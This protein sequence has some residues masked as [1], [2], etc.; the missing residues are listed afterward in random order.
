[1]G[2]SIMKSKYPFHTAEVLKNFSP[3]PD[4][5]PPSSLILHKNKI[6]FIAQTNGKFVLWKSDG[7]TETTVSIWNFHGPV[8]HLTSSGEFIYFFDNDG[9]HGNELWRSDG[10][11]EGTAMVRDIV[12]GSTGLP[13]TLNPIVNVNGILYFVTDD[14]EHGYELWKSDGTES[15]TIMVRDIAQGSTSSDPKELSALNGQLYF[16]ADDRIYGRELWKTDGTTEG[17]QMLNDLNQGAYS[18]SPTTF[19][20]HKNVLYFTAYNNIVRTL[21]KTNGNACGTIM[22]TSNN[23]VSLED[24]MEI[25][26]NKI[27]V[28]GWRA[29]TGM[30]L[31]LHNIDNDIPISEECK[32]VQEII[33][34]Q[35]DSKT[36]GQLFQLKASS[37][38]DMPIEFTTT[39]P[40]LIS[41]NGRQVTTIKPGIAMITANQFGDNEVLAASTVQRNFCINPAKPVLSSM[42]TTEGIQLTAESP[43]A[44]ESR[45][46]MNGEIIPNANQSTLLVNSP[47]IYTAIAIADEC[48]SE[49]SDPLNLTA[50]TITSIVPKEDII[51]AIYPNPAIKLLQLKTLTNMNR[52]VTIH[53]MNVMGQTLYSKDIDF[54]NRVDYSIDLESYPTGQYLIL[55]T[56]KVGTYIT[57]R[58]IKL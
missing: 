5:A 33:F 47:G 9:I 18:S 11:V 13:L 57:R 25:V 58:I 22:V 53:I 50:E 19:R 21:W 31:F 16:S 26:D 35:I 39:T 56:D 51:I 17:T 46:L 23:Q 43:Y 8:S 2:F 20:I 40:E 27:F 6:Y 32:L 36:Y 49:E 41:I 28:T 42:K 55:I 48:S 12:P 44:T 45:W 15:G 30:E 3:D 10:T 24:Q 54:S 4:D 52:V 14:G 7:T 1:M 34:D 37:T 29:D 38:L